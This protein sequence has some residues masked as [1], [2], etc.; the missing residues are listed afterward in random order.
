MR[1]TLKELFSDAETIEQRAAAST[2]TASIDTLITPK[3]TS[4]ET[5]IEE[6]LKKIGAK[7]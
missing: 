3:K 1:N 2:V 5:N 4:T 7:P 6:L